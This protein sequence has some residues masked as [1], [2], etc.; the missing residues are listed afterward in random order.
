MCAYAQAF[1]LVLLERRLFD[2]S[3][4][5]WQHGP[6]IRVLYR[7]YCSCGKAAL[8]TAVRADESRAPFSDEELFILETVGNYYGRY[9]AP[10]LRSMSHSDFPGDFGPAKP[11]IPDSAIVARFNENKIIQKI[12]SAY[13]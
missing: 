9:R 7:Q 8:S 1:S 2:E 11:E 13:Q 3:L 10:V 12:R 6:V 4:E 5:A